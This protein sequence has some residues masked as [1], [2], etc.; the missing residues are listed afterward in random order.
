[1][2]WDAKLYDQKHG[3]VA[4]YGTNLLEYVP[5]G[6]ARALDL[7]CGT[8][9]L[10]AQL[11]EK[12]AYV[13]GVDGSAEMIRRARENYP[14]L[15]FAVQD[16]LTL[17][18]RQAWDVVFSNAVFHWIADH[19]ALLR[20]VHQALR[21]GGLLVCEFGGAG[22]IAAIEQSFAAALE[23]RGQAYHSKFHFSGAEEFERRLRKAGFTVRLL[24]AYDRPTP[25][26][27]GAQGLQNWTRQFFEKELETVPPDER[28]A[29]LAE[30]DDG[31]KH[32]WN[33]TEWVADYKRIRAVAQA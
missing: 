16:A 12:C 31:A 10:T 13:R 24:T 33:G 21:P 15:D 9:T 17:C 20:V 22:N 7:G 23:R 2:Q 6:T 1:M 27:D 3:F 28:A 26:R 19:D 25:L 11:G 18:D 14:A 4:E 29:V 8:G 30:V 32:L 5:D